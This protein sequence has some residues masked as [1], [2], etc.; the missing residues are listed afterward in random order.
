MKIHAEFQQKNGG[1]PT[2]EWLEARLGVVTASEFGRIVKLDGTMRDGEMVKTYLAEKLFERWTGRTKEP[3][4]TQATNNGVIVEER[5]AAF[6]EFQYGLKIDHV[7]FISDAGGSIGCSPDGLVGWDASKFSK[8]EPTVLPDC[9][10]PTAAQSGIEIKCPE[11]TTHIKYLLDGKLPKD[12]IPQVQGSMFVTGCKIWHFLSYPLTC[13]LDGFPALHLLVER[14]E[15]FCENLSESLEKFLALYETS[16]ARL[17]EMNG[18]PPPPRQKF[19]S[20]FNQQ[21]Q[22]DNNDIPTP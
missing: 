4:V 1:D 13:C 3:F 8:T 17:V 14:D 22:S 16:F 6:A 12:Y 19:F 9:F 2:R 5:A 18:A 7:G 20:S 15:E 21:P 11:H 10:T